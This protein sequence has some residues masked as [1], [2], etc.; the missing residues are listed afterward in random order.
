MSYKKLF[1]GILLVVIGTLFILKNLGWIYFD[2]GT[3]FHLWP[4]ILILWGISLIPI[5]DYIK[6]ILSLV[7]ILLTVILVTKFENRNQSSFWHKNN[8]N[9][10]FEFNDDNEN[11]DSTRISGDMQELFQP[12]DSTIK[13]ATLFFDAAA[14][15]YRLIDSTFTDK[16]MLFRKKGNIGNYSMMSEDSDNSRTINLKIDDSKIRLK[17]RGNLVQ[18]YLNPQ[19][20]WDFN[21]DIGAASIDFDL[22]K[23]KVNNLKVNGGASSIKLRLGAKNASTNVEVD[24]GAASMDFFVPESAGVQLRTETVLTSRNING[25]TK[26]SNG[27]YRTSNYNGAASVINIT[28]NAGVSSINVTRY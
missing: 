5:K 17:N 22:S 3:F 21:F 12:Y 23:F 15:D 19:P 7:A 2:W 4:L 27:L 26:V 24:A 20:A 9:W 11:F 14:G 18:L 8:S 6:L 28:I 10:E 1:W 25:F 16:L 13:S